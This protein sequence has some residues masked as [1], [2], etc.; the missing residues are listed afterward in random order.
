MCACVH[1]RGD[2]EIISA[3]FWQSD[4]DKFTVNHKHKNKHLHNLQVYTWLINNL[5]SYTAVL[6]LINDISERHRAPKKK[7]MQEGA[8]FKFV[9]DRRK[10]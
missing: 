1:V 3:I 10:G 5:L 2:R 4:F 7:W 8:S 6:K 9:G